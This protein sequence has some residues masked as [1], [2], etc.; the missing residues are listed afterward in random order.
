MSHKG[1]KS[2]PFSGSNIPIS[3]QEYQEAITQGVKDAIR[4][5]SKDQY[6]WKVRK[7]PEKYLWGKFKDDHNKKYDEEE[8]QCS[9]AIAIT[10]NPDINNPI[11]SADLQVLENWSWIEDCWYA[12]EYKNTDR[13]SPHVHIYVEK[14]LQR[15]PSE[16]R[17]QL[18]RAFGIRNHKSI[19]YIRNVYDKDGWIDYC[20][21]ECQDISE[22]KRIRSVKNLRKK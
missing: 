19:I 3:S 22:F 10:I 8:T 16:I 1:P 12:F 11:T 6:L 15:Y 18:S 20:T 13:R 7:N 17:Q 9:K 14:A 4:Q 2:S 5:L 21:K